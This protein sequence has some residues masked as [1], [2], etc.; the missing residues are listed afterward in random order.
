[1]RKKSKRQHLPLFSI[2]ENTAR[3]PLYSI[4]SSEMNFSHRYLSLDVMMGGKLSPQKRP[5]KSEY[6]WAPSRTSRTS[7]SHL[8]DGSRWK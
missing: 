6:P 7:N 1:M 4:V 5:I 8:F 3:K 2:Y